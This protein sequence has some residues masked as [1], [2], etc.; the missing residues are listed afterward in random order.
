MERYNPWWI[1]EKD[2]EYEKW[3]KSPIKW[4][5][6]IINE[7]SLK[8]FSLNFLSG[9]RQVGKTTAIKILIYKLLENHDAKGI[10]Y[11][12]C[13][14]LSDYKELGEVIDNY[15]SSRESWKIKKSFIFLDEITFVDDWWRTLKSRIDRGV[16]K[17]DVITITGSASIEL[18]RQKEYFP[19]RRGYGKD[20]V[21]LPLRFSEYLTKIEKLPISFGEIRRIDEN[22][23]K[24]KL[25][26]EKIKE[27]FYRY[28]QSGGFPLSIIDV[29]TKGKVT[30]QTIRTYLDWMRNDWVKLGKNEKY[31]KEV[32][33]YIIRARGTAISWNGIASETSINSP[34]TAQSY[35][36]ILEKMFVVKILYFLSP[37]GKIMYRK[38]KKVHFL[39]PLMYQVF[40]EYVKED[41]DLSQ[42]YEALVAT[43]LG[44]FYPTY[45]WKN[46]TEVDVI[47]KV[48]DEI[49]GFEVTK[50]I[51]RWRKPIFLKKAHLLDRDNIHLYLSAI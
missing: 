20:C 2:Y 37:D 39:D 15:L 14:E 43:T 48:D 50:G 40:S 17:N 21:L 1:G 12:S 30:L 7:I 49:V 32:I 13:D 51:K 25:F 18:L 34:H 26:E 27:G 10:F 16:F 3:E 36:E 44:R 8:P 33:S 42:I 23:K 19:G 24:N 47:C 6:D 31:M 9:P 41:Y 4:I 5:P 45:Y 46:S 29:K 28:I 35:V 11:Y 38:N 22:M